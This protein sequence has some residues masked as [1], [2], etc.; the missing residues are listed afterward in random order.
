MLGVVPSKE[1]L[2]RYNKEMSL[3]TSF[4][5]LTDL[6]KQH[7]STIFLIVH[8]PPNKTKQKTKPQDQHFDQGFQSST[9]S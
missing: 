4:L 6:L 8:P 7:T 1:T 3:V 9:Q 2:I 5:F